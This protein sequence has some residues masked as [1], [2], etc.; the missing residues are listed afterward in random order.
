MLRIAL[1][2]Q[3]AV[4]PLTA[5]EVKARLNI[6]SEV[7]DAVIDA[8]IKAARQE[9]DGWTGWLGRALINQTYTLYLPSFCQYIDLPVPPVSSVASVKYIDADGVEQTVDASNYELLPGSP[10]RLQPKYSLYWPSPRSQPDAVRVAFVAGYGS[11]GSSVPEPI[12]I[13]ICLMVSNM[14]SLSA[15]NLFVS[16]DTAEG[17]G[18]KRYVVGEGAGNALTTAASRLLSVYRV[19]RL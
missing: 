4:E 12:R 1:T 7:T 18:T 16:E 15:R 8:Y 13:A 17:V 3:P 6:G 19:L 10:A 9:I 14:R 11:T 2:T 5:A